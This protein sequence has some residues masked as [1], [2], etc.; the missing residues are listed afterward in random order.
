MQVAIVEDD[1]R[2]AERLKDYFVRY[3]SEHE[4]EVELTF[5]SNANMFL[6]KYVGNFDLVMMDIEMPGINGMNAAKKLREMD[7]E[8]ILIFVTNMAQYAVKGYEVDAMDFIVKPVNYADFAF[9]I[10]RVSHALAMRRQPQ[11]TITTPSGMKRANLSSLKYVEVSGH[12]VSYHFLD[13]TITIRGSL[14]KVEES[15]KDSHFM[16]CNSCYLVNP[17]HITEVKGYS[18]FL[19]SEELAIS[20]PKK[21]AFMQELNAWIAGGGQ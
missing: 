1:N 10:T 15:L 18:V 12:N 14:S 2:A 17:K 16:K 6:D 21:K 8:V 3:Q 11:I 7:R 13:E 5:F 9:K 19:G 20:H 4:L